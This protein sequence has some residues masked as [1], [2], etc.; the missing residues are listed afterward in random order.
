MIDLTSGR[1]RNLR[2]IDFIKKKRVRRRLGRSEKEYRLTEETNN[3][4]V[5]ED[6]HQL[7]EGIYEVILE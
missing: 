3:K 7:E 1:R 6:Q 5:L 2:E 4:L